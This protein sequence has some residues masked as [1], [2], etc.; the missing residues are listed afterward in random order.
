[1]LQRALC[2]RA[3]GGGHPAYSPKRRI[4]RRNQG[5]APDAGLDAFRLGHSRKTRLDEDP[6]PGLTLLG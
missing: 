3:G 1:M 4:G 6:C 2:I 5:T